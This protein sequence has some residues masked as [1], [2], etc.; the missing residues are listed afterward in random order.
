[1]NYWFDMVWY[2]VQCERGGEREGVG[3]G[4]GEEKGRKRWR[5]I[6]FCNLS[7][8]CSLSNIII[9]FISY[10]FYEFLKNVLLINIL[11][12]YYIYYIIKEQY[13]FCSK[14]K[15]KKLI[16]KINMN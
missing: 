12:F 3:E 10:H 8:A 13:N 5:E 6:E 4:K 7:H 11:I 2:G 16:K 15:I 1:M 9:N 14:K